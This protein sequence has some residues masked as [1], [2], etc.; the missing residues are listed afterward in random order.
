MRHDSEY[1]KKI[2]A[3]LNEAMDE[4]NVTQRDIA[5]LCEV[6]STSVHNYLH[7]IAAPTKENIEKLSNYLDVN[8]EWLSGR[9]ERKYTD[10]AMNIRDVPQELRDLELRY[11]ELPEEG[12][13]EMKSYL[14]Y[15]RYKYKD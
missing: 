6:S 4:K 12:R 5:E 8:P 13:A 11:L 3:R 1:F 10:F 15:L 9:S 7:G 2:G 14:E